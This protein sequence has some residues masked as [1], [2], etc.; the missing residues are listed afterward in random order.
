MTLLL[1]LALAS[2]PSPTPIRVASSSFRAVAGQAV[3]L[4]DFYGEHFATQLGQQPGFQVTTPG[5]LSA[6]LGLERQK[7]LL[8]C[9]DSANSC[10]AELASAL[11]VEVLLIGEVAK[12]DTTSQ[13]NVRALNANSGAV[14]FAISRR[15]ATKEA[16]LD[17]LE[18]AARETA[19]R[20]RAVLG[21][22]AVAASG[23]GVRWAPWVVSGA[24]L[25]AAGV[26]VGLLVDANLSHEALTGPASAEFPPSVARAAADSG[27]LSQAVGSVL[28]G[29]GVAAA[30]T[31]LIW[32]FAGGD[33]P[34]PVAW[35]AP[36]A[37]GVGIA[38][39]WP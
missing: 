11:G 9:A 12:L 35:V 13:V 37:G 3:D 15:A 39:T 36:G 19:Q 5:A 4:A 21:R 8:G 20:L 16:M 32:F 25:V 23:G 26:G 14:F 1:A 6:A 2:A 30:A 27:K 17:A 7:Q 18:D 38:G 24:G 31:G 34:T 33:G 10:L 28:V 22:E 29:V